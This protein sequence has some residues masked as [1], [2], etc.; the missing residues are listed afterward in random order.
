MVAGG[1]WLLLWRTRLRLW[2]LAAIAAGI[3]LAPMGS[4]PDLLVGRDGH[5]VAVRGD[6]GRLAALT[7]VPA[8]FE[9]ARWLKHDGD[10][11]SPQ[12]AAKAAAFRCD[13][14]GCVVEVRGATVAVARHAAAL[15]DDCQR[16][17]ILVLPLPR[18][19]TCTRPPLILD[20]I[21]LRAGGTHALYLQPGADPRIETVAGERGDRPWSRPPARRAAFRSSQLAT[22]DPIGR[23]R[24]I[25]PSS[26]APGV[27]GG[28]ALPRPEIED[29][30]ATGEVSADTAAVEIAP[31]G[32]TPATPAGPD[33]RAPTIPAEPILPTPR[34][35]SVPAPRSR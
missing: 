22:S 8:N 31:S 32:A 6:D 19:R 13:A 20:F 23:S 16:A 14:A 21:A 4:R 5:L 12:E 25:T 2:G 24:V 30:E 10:A 17:G 34:P 3:A 1:L 26:A 15:R 29:E 7:A 11:R 27:A 9:L 33:A 18:P 28:M 35:P